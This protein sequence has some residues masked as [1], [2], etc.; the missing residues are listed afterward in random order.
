MIKKEYELDG[1]IVT[2][3][4]NGITVKVPAD[5]EAPERSILELEKEAAVML[6]ET[7]LKQ[8][9]FEADIEYI[10]CLMELLLGF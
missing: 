6:S 10:K 3:Y 7:Y 2:E 9:N 4:D 1:N 8:M 5:H